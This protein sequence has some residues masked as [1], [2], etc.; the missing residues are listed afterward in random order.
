MMVENESGQRMETDKRI[1]P[2]SIRLSVLIRCRDLLNKPHTF[3]GATMRADLLIYN[4]G[5]LVTPVGAAT[6]GPRHG[7]EMRELL[8]IANAALAVADGRILAVGPETE[9]RGQYVATRELDA[10][11]RAVIPGFV[12]PHTH[13]PWAGD[14]AAE[15]EMRVGGATYMEIMAAGGGIVRTVADT[16]AASLETLIAQTRVRLD[17]MLAHGTTTAEAKTG[18]GLAT[19]DEIKQLLALAEL[20]GSHPVDLVPTFM[21][22]HAIPP[23][24]RN[25]ADAYIDLIVGEM[26]PAFRA[27][28]ESRRAGFPEDWPIFCDVFCETGAFDLAQTRRVLEAARD[29][30]FSLKIHVDEFAPLGGTPLGIELGAVSVDHLVTT[31]PE[32]ISLLAASETIGVSLPGTPFGLGHRDYTPAR[33]L[34][35]QGGSLALATDLNPGTC[36]CESMQLMIALAGRY[37]RLLPAEALTAATLNAAC[38]V[39]LGHLAGSLE[40]GKLADMVLLDA[41]DYRMLGYRFG[42]NLAA[43]VVKRGQVVAGG[44]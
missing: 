23:E 7:H 15:F 43:A 26:L 31:P 4:I 44:F 27:E 21:A 5:Q 38:A 14:R 9:L 8:V 36:W 24:Y 25:R 18:Y 42:T 17:R 2:I 3:K 37:M 30:G 41:D 10:R 33:S 20:Q 12:D 13:L 1:W 34:I 6:G 32:H 35:D 19:N 40:P 39:G 22:A 28:W 29:L 11:R 16:R